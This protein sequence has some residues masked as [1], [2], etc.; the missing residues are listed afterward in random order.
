MGMYLK[1]IP[2]IQ[3]HFR[4]LIKWFALGLLILALALAIFVWTFDINDYRDAL[5][6][7]ASRAL[8]AT[9]TIEGPL[10]IAL[11]LH[12]RLVTERIK[13]ANPSWASRP[14]LLQAGRGE[15]QISLLPLLKGELIIPNVLLANLDL[16]LE[17]GPGGTSNWVFE[18]T[19]PSSDTDDS[20]A[21]SSSSSIANIE[22]VTIQESTIAYRSLPSYPPFKI[23]IARATVSMIPDNPLRLLVEGRVR[24]IPISSAVTT[25]TIQE[26]LAPSGA[27][28]IKASLSVASTSILLDGTVSDSLKKVDFGFEV[29]GDRLDNL[30]PLVQSSLPPLGPFHVTGRIANSPAQWHLADLN[31][32]VNRTEI[33]GTAKTSEKNPSQDFAI[34]L[35][36]KTFYVDDF[37]VKEP[38]PSEITP[39]STF[40]SIGSIQIP[41]DYLKDL[42]AR[43]GIN[44]GET[45]LNDQSLGP[46]SLVANA[47]DGLLHI[48]LLRTGQFIGK[49]SLNLKIDARAKEPS[50]R[51]KGMADLIDYGRILKTLEVTQEIEGTSKL[52]FLFSGQGNSVNEILKRSTLSIQAGPSQW[53]HTDSNSGT[54]IQV[55]IQRLKGSILPNRAVEFNLAGRYRKKPLGFRLTGGRVRDLI[56]GDEPWPI[57]LS[58]RVADA[59]LLVKGQLFQEGGDMGVSLLA[60]IQGER[61]TTFDPDLPPLGPYRVTTKIESKDKEILVPGLKARFGDTTLTGSLRVDF[62]G[63]RTWVKGEMTSERLTFED[64]FQ[65]TPSP[66][67]VDFFQAFDFNLGVQARRAITGQL[68]LTDF[69]ADISL[70]K[71]LL[72]VSPLQG[73]LAIVE[74]PT[75]DI[76]GL[77]KLNFADALPTLTARMEGR[78]WPYGKVLQDLEFP[79]RIRGLGNFTLGLRGAG[80]TIGTMIKESSITITTQMTEL[81]VRKGDHWTLLKDVKITFLSIDGESS[82]LSLTGTT[83]SI[84]V[85][86][87]LQGDSINTLFEQRGRWPLAVAAEIGTLHLK[88]KGRLN[89]PFDGENFVLKTL[90]T[91]KELNDLDPILSTSLPDLGP[92]DISGTVTDSPQGVE[93][94]G[95]KGHLQESDI[96]GKLLVALKGPRPRVEGEFTSEKI[97]IPQFNNTTS[98]ISDSEIVPDS[99]EQGFSIGT[100]SSELGSLFPDPGKPPLPFLDTEDEGEEAEGEVIENN[101]ATKGNDLRGTSGNEKRLIPDYALPVDALQAVDLDISLR[102]MDLDIP[103]NDVGDFALRIKLENGELTLAPITGKLWGG[104]VDGSLTINARQEV[105]L[106]HGR[107][108]IHDLD[109]GRSLATRG[110]TEDVKGIV[111]KIEID[112]QGQGG[113]LREILSQANGHMKWV[114]GEMELGKKYIDLWAADLFTTLLTSAWETEEVE[115][116]NCAVINLDVKNG[117][118]QTNEILIDTKRVTVAG[119]GNLDLGTEQIDVLL[120]PEP[121]DPTLLS[122]GHPVRVSGALSDPNISAD[123]EDLLKSA[124]WLTLGITVPVLLPITVPKVMGAGLGTGENPCEAALAGQPIKPVRSRERSF[125][126]RITGF[127]KGSEEPE[128]EADSL[129]DIKEN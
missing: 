48:E 43:V 25:G 50:I 102:I 44:I 2:P 52:E 65:P 94:F 104:T 28:P 108:Q 124:G 86:L 92:F 34:D 79:D 88:V 10:D 29:S 61:I 84:P 76:Q 96:R 71:G 49:S 129:P 51:F 75:A 33:T 16:L 45:R 85:S 126:D 32:T 24:N 112:L 99:E 82:Q 98:E 91:G 30:N 93:V 103:P 53:I 63:P 109:Y 89:L 69:S 3:M 55:E 19:S 20:P 42:V 74:S 90:V 100:M 114:D 18:K 4:P 120:T 41:S 107:T 57:M 125:F 101:S 97:V 64:I 81:G 116:L 35:T 68:H 80:D 110:I 40:G 123:K 12:P 39:E 7:S 122:L 59:S 8:G 113:T 60:G 36:A 62:S 13:I 73:K 56:D 105:P 78:N 15:I 83:Q 1:V 128:K 9:V 27:W 118:A 70:N 11:S 22:L 127:W 95:L 5:A 37:L 31:L 72:T 66:L 111:Q 47:E 67:P 115:Y 14:H 23:D 119:A 38:H 121:K 58:G 54:Q 106:I 17:E 26:L 87:N 6:A 117:I 21:A 46:V 77:L